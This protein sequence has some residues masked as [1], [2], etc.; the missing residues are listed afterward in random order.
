MYTLKCHSYYF[1]A[2]GNETFMLK[3]WR[4][5]TVDLILEEN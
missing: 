3:W 1:A 4:L 5:I 2:I